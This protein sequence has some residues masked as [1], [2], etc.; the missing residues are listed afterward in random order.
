MIFMTALSD[1]KD[2]VTGFNL[3]AVDYITKPIRYEEVLMRV[4][5][6]LTIQ[7]LQG[8]LK[9]KNR[10]LE[11]N[12]ADLDVALE[13]E[14]ELNELK[15]RFISIASHEFRTPLSAILLLSEML[16]SYGDQL[17]D[18]QRENKFSQLRNAVTQMTRL[19]DD[20]LLIS[21]SDS[22]KIPFST[23]PTDLRKFVEYIVKEF[24]NMSNGTHE[25][26]FNCEPNNYQA[27][28]DSNLFYHVVANLL[29]NALKYSPVNSQISVTL[30][31][32]H[33]RLI[34]S[35]SDTGI[36][37]P[38]EDQAQLFDAFHR[39]KNAGKVEGSGLGLSIAKQFVEL[40]GGSIS[41]ESE[42]GKGSTFRVSIPAI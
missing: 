16:E 19:L 36:G 9:K 12:N 3:G 1:T 32:E 27:Q 18:K 41:L 23:R 17:S 28:L 4:K 10:E 30:E 38:E 7:N 26:R 35:V 6:H 2:K 37:V 11:I 8:Q 20:I 14:K 29:S 33:N 34:I 13:K 15:T 21:K 25:I 31:R 40:H 39:A 24:S 42:V 22:G 5:T